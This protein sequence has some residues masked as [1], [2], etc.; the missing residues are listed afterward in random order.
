MTWEV[1]FLD[2]LSFEPE[3]NK[4]L[5]P[6]VIIRRNKKKQQ[7]CFCALSHHLTILLM[8]QQKLDLNKELS[9]L[10]TKISQKENVII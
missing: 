8:L 2:Q 5:N 7:W 6:R 10:E 4:N 9:Q 1:S 3:Y